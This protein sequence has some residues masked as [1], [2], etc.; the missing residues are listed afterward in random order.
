MDKYQQLKDVIDLF[1]KDLTNVIENRI[2]NARI[3]IEQNNEEEKNIEK[4]IK[5]I[6]EKIQNIK[7]IPKN[8]IN[9][10]VEL[11][12]LPKI[13]VEVDKLQKD[14][15]YKKKELEALRKYHEEEKEELFNENNKNLKKCYDFDKEKMDIIGCITDKEIFDNMIYQKMQYQEYDRLKKMNDAIFNKY[16]PKKS[17]EE[18]SISAAAPVTNSGNLTTSVK[19]YNKPH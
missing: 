5:L 17:E 11:N 10:N 15:F 3:R 6:E 13:Y 4:E 9:N 16:L 7:N 19:I 2:E 1:Y 12:I 8:H 18:N 14:I